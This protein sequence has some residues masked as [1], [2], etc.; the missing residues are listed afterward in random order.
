MLIDTQNRVINYLRVSVT[1][2]CNLRCIYC[3][4]RDGVDMKARSEILSFEELEKIISVAAKSGVSK[5]RITGGEP[6]IRKGL[7][8][9]I[10]RISKISEIKDLSMTTNGIL[11]KENAFALKAAGLQRVNVSLDTLDP[12][13]YREIT[14]NGEIERV[15]DGIF[16]AEKAGLL[17]VKINLVVVRG[18]ND[19]ELCDFSQLTRK[20]QYDIRFIEY[21]P[22]GA[23][24]YWSKEKFMSSSEILERISKKLG[25]LTP[26]ETA[27]H[28]PATYFKLSNSKGRIGVISPISNHFCSS[29]NKLRLTSDG[30]LRAC[31]FSD[32]EVDLKAILRSNCSAENINNLLKE[33]VLRKP[34]DHNLKE[35]ESFLLERTMSQIGG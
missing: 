29:C 30:R 26:L 10:S 14:E 11:L 25:E 13:K 9:F 17:P 21:M 19:N 2:R 7:I 23:T 32:D 3:M 12:Q 28:S 15:W 6:L 33:A 31:L 27:D 35:G 16:E 24:N 22:V 20:Y 34:K 5:V 1:D 8:D 18:L 4:S